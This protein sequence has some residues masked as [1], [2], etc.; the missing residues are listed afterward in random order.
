[1]VRY[2]AGGVRAQLLIL[3]L[4]LQPTYEDK[5]NT[6]KQNET[7]QIWETGRGDEPHK[8]NRVDATL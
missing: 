6:A 5:K 4:P 1:M 2:E 3:I 7:D 8:G